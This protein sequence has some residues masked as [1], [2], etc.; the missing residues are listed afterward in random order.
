MEILDIIL[1]IIIVVCAAGGLLLHSRILKGTYRKGMF[2]YYTNLSNMLVLLFYLLKLIGMPLGWKGILYSDGAQFTVTMSI[3]ITFVIYHFIIDP[4]VRKM[5]GFDYAAFNTADNKIV[6]YIVPLLCFVRW[7][8]FA[9]KEDLTF[10]SA[11]AWTIIPLIYVA[12][13]LIHANCGEHFEDTDSRYPYEFM[14][15]DKLGKKRVAINIVFLWAACVLLGCIFIGVSM[16][17][18]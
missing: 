6:H 10:G 4:S 7:V 8:F 12:F 17:F 11:F 1:Q 16:L 18:S 15:V 13:A 5:P 9:F 14:D 3:L 2:L